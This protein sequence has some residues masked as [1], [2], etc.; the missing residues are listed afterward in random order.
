MTTW[1]NPRSSPELMLTFH[2]GD[3]NSSSPGPGDAAQPWA[4]GYGGT[5]AAGDHPC[6]EVKEKKNSVDLVH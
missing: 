5:A 1:R 3:V 2:D 6:S 4:M